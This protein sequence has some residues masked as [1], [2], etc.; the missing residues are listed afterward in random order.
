MATLSHPS[1]PVDSRSGSTARPAKS[2]MH[3]DDRRRQLL[4]A[5]IETFSRKGFGGTKTKDIA[6]AAGVSE[7]ILFRHFATK[8]DLYNAILDEQ[9]HQ[10]TAEDDCRKID[11]LMRKRDDAGVF[12]LMGAQI[13]GVFRDDPA[14]HRLIVYAALEGHVMARLFRERIA[15]RRGDFLKRYI[16]QR[17]KEGAFRKMDPAVVQLAIMGPF[18]HYAMRRYVF[19][20]KGP[21]RLGERPDECVIEEIVAIALDGLTGP[22]KKSPNKLVQETV[23][24]HRDRKTRKESHAKA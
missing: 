3:G 17:Q 12:R 13:I 19:G 21:G 5:A 2:R 23:Y 6:A 15:T 18:I 9:E 22:K 20:F 16:L 4:R 11:E 7:A 8:E 1:L 14:F 24:S 10:A